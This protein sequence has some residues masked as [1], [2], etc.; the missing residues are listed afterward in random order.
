MD[1]K[2]TPASCENE[3]TFDIVEDALN[4]L[5]QVVNELSR[6]RPPLQRHFRVTIFGSARVKP[7]QPLYDDVRR[8]AA[9]L[10]A[11]GC[12]IVTGGGPGLMQAANEGE[13]FGDPDNKTR[14][15]GLPVEL[16]F[17]ERANPF[18]EKLY[19]HRTFFSRLHHFVRLS[20]AFVVVGGGI[21]TTL[22]TMIVWQLLQVRHIQ[23]VPLILVGDMWKGLVDWAKADMLSHD[24]P[25]ASPRDLD[26]PVCVQSIDDAIAAVLAQKALYDAARQG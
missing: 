11:Q 16:P 19:H 20:S 26:I 3:E 1:D 18:V 10:S 17:E 9:A 2:K 15:F 13:N 25:F 22:E 21:G 4:D 7:G 12:D 14:S 23:D 5:W 6:I 8:L 24:P